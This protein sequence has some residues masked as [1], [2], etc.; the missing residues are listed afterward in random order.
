MKDLIL[1]YETKIYLYEN[2]IKELNNIVNNLYNNGDRHF[3]NQRIKELE[4][5]KESYNKDLMIIKK[6]GDVNGNVS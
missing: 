3:V 2:I 5:L 1:Y 6:L 4:N